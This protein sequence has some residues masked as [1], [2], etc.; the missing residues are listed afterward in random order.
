MSDLTL[1]VILLEEAIPI[2]EP[3]MREFSVHSSIVIAP[4]PYM[5]CP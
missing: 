1:P 5:G 4:V 2:F 3:G